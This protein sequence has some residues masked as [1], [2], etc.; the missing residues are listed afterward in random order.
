VTLEPAEQ[1]RTALVDHLALITAVED[2]LTLLMGRLEAD[3]A[4]TEQLILANRSAARAS[5]YATDSHK[6]ASP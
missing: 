5:L 4:R 3:R 6:G 2:T 1:L